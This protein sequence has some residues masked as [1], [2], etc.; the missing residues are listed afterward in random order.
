MVWFFSVE[1][2]SQ[3]YKRKEGCEK[4]SRSVV[5]NAMDAA[6]EVV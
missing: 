1:G 5:S 4:G 6:V 3:M 2:T